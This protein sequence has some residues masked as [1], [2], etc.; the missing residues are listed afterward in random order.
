MLQTDLDIDS[1]RRVLSHRLVGCQVVYH[2][3]LGS[4]MDEAR[5]LAERGAAEGTVVVVEAQTAGRGRFGRSWLSPRGQSIHVSVVLAPT[6]AQ[7]PYV[8]MAAALSVCHAIA[9]ATDLK[10]SVKWPNDV[11]VNGRK[12]AGILVETAMEG[13]E[14]RHAVVGIGVNANLDPSDFPEIASTATSIAGETGRPVDRSGLLTLVLERLDE[15]YRGVKAGHSLT[16][17]WAALLETL[18]RN[19][20]V[21]WRDQVVEGLAKS[22]DEQGNLVLLMPDGSTFTA[23]AGE[24]T[25]QT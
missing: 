1:L 13:D 20:Q 7:L 17:E 12:I 5:R 9:E 22:V 16:S 10:P 2:E 21:R 15:L 8:N 23:V 25:S 19:V 14:V 24:V 18:G 4:T 3:T 11:R 6:I